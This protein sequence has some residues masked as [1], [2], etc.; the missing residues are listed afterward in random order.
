M[1]FTH[2]S[3]GVWKDH[4]RASRAIWSKYLAFCMRSVFGE[5]GSKRGGGCPSA[6][7][8]SHVPT[9]QLGTTPSTEN[10]DVHVRN[11]VAV[12]EDIAINVAN[13]KTKK[14]DLSKNLLP[15]IK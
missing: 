9:S 5:V 8:S 13:F 15:S 7:F 2:L 6:R 12:S 11:F 14:C 10:M 4:V 3:S 1:L